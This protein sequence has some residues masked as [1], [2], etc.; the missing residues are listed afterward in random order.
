MWIKELTLE[1]IKGF[2]KINLKFSN[3]KEPV[4]WITLLGENGG[5]KSTVLQALGLLLAGPE[6][7]N[8]LLPV[9]YGWVRTEGMPGKMTIIIH[10]GEKDPGTFGQKRETKSFSYTFFVTGSEKTIIR[11]RTFTEPT[12]IE[13]PDKRLSWLKENALSSKSKGWFAAGYGAFRRLTRESRVIIPT[14]TSQERHNNFTT[15]FKEDEALSSFEQ[16]MVYLDYRIA[17]GEKDSKKQ[18]QKQLSIAVEAINKILPEGVAF[19]SVSEDGK[20]MFDVK[21]VKVSTI[22]LSDGYRSILALM[23]DLIWRMLDH[24]PDSDNPLLE[25]GVV[26]ID[27]LD[28]H[29]HP[30]WQRKIAMLLREQ[31][32][33][34]Q[35]IVATH[36]PMITAGAGPDAQTYRFVF[37]GNKT[38]V[39]E[40]KDLAFL[41]V[42]R[43]LASNAFSLISPFSPQTE[44]QIEKYLKLKKKPS[45]TALDKKEL[46]AT[47]P[48]V[49]KAYAAPP[50]QEP[51]Q[52]KMDE[53][54]KK[55][56]Q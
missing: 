7:V 6:N 30:V 50:D 34:I 28:I 37:D 16:W 54:L 41:S 19:N 13:N 18:A 2:E 44:L 9:P 25:E 53:Y 12:I 40:I 10:Q 31:F 5:G 45:L 1:N 20:I 55:I 3:K 4:H 17:K 35:F 42:D 8:K 23:G 26:L 43:I 27:E 48:F 47:I 22:G 52:A 14:I 24:F 56:L 15:Q 32:P 38:K 36:S 49:E 39:N 33:N 46:Q 51:L 21:G 29:L 11:T